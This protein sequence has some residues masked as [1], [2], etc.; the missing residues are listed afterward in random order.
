MDYFLAES[1][2]TKDF[3]VLNIS[4]E[5]FLYF[6]FQFHV[7]YSALL[8]PGYVLKPKWRESTYESSL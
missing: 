1:S 8:Q 5:I 7:I 6:V 4:C 2:F 3:Q